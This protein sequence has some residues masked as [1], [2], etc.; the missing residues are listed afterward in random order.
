MHKFFK[1]R[2]G[3]LYVAPAM[4]L[5]T[6]FHVAPLPILIRTSLSN[7]NSIKFLEFV[8]FQNYVAIFKN[9]PE[10]WLAHKN[11][12]IGLAIALI[13]GVPLAMLFA[14]LLDRTK[15]WL[16]GVFKFSVM[17]PSVLSVAVM[18]QLYKGFLDADKGIFNNLFRLFGKD[19]WALPWL[20]MSKTAYWAIQVVGV[21]FGS[22]ITIILFY[23]AIKA[24]P[25]QYYEAAS[26]DGANFWQICFKITIP[27]LQDI[28][29]YVVVTSTTGSLCAWDLI[30][31]LTGGGP[32][33]ATYTVMY[34]IKTE[35]FSA[36]HFGKSCAAA[37]IFFIE[38]VTISF[39][40]NK[41][42]D[43]E[44]IEY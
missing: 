23:A 34:Y 16:R 22:G 5:Y 3:W 2:D 44:P 37:F 21:L 7:H 15:G 19:E 24:I 28:T 25:P 30:Q 20:S 29:K 1:Q 38:C 26:I 36:Y 14:L 33:K 42:L 31:C 18:G 17:L 27:M 41:L 43:K 12:Y 35:G 39:L 8:G 6:V 32:G 11:T 10:F 13:I 40:V 9:T 4:L